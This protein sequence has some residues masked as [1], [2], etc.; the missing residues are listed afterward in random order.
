[1]ARTAKGLS[2]HPQHGF[3]LTIGKK[4]DGKPRLFWLG[5]ARTTAEYHA[6]ALKGQLDFM[7]SGDGPFNR[8]ALNY[9]FIQSSITAQS[10]PCP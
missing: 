4:A 10:E 7:N 6:D 3:R 2:K 9:P 8:A 1:M 5:H